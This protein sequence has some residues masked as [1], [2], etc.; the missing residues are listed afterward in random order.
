MLLSQKSLNSMECN[1]LSKPPMLEFQE[2]IEEKYE[3]NLVSSM[4]L[5]TTEIKVEEEN[6]GFKTPTKL[7]D[8]NIVALICPPAPR[9]PKM[10]PVLSKRKV[11][12]SRPRI[13]LDM[14][15]EIESLFPPAIR[16]DLG[17]NN[18]F[19]TDHWN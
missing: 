15:K 13:Y 9:K 6:E 8:K 3:K 19:L 5:A 7:V 1:F 4:K 17:G 18:W 12:H 2:E 16:A 10:V 14:S 11:L